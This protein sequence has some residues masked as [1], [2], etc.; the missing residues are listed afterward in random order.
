VKVFYQN[1]IYSQFYTCFGTC[2]GQSRHIDM[3][4]RIYPEIIFALNVFST[5]ECDKVVFEC[6]LIFACSNGMSSLH[7][8]AVD[9]KTH[10]EHYNLLLSAG[11]LLVTLIYHTVADVSVYPP[12]FFRRAGIAQS[13]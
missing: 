1:C 9:S 11:W 12:P 2:Y 10:F 4:T 8:S 3:C 5:P 13:V 7:I 6:R